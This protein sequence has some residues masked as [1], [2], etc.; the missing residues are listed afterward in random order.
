[1]HQITW[2]QA[3][4]V[5]PDTEF[6]L[7]DKVWRTLEKVNEHTYQ[8][9]I[10]DV[11]SPSYATIRLV[12]RSEV[13]SVTANMRIYMQIPLAGTEFAP[14]DERAKQAT[15]YEPVELKALRDLTMFG[16]KPLN[17]P[18]LLDESIQ[19]QD[20]N[21]LVPGGFFICYVWETVPGLCL[22]DAFGSDAFWALDKSERSKIKAALP[23]EFEYI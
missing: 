21:G 13:E 10:P 5:F 8:K 4:L 3:H 19:M 6:K 15:T 1:M 17:T 12:C 7:Q 23:R 20:S 9:D 18:R 22:R 16:S 2:F 11:L 14:A